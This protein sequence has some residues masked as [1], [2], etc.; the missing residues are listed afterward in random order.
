MPEQPPLTDPR[1]MRKQD[2]ALNDALSREAFYLTAFRPSPNMPA[3]ELAARQARIDELAA[4]GL[5]ML[6]D[7]KPADP[8]R[9]G[10]IAV[11]A[12]VRP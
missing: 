2:A 4:L 6:H 7:G 1:E 3:D 12:R 9:Y 11:D 8:E 5:P 10:V